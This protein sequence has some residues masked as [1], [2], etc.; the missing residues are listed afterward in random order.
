M[1]REYDLT[2]RPVPRIETQFRRIITEFPVPESVPILQRLQAHEPVAMRGQPP[3]VWDH[4]EGFQVYDAWGNQWI[5]WSSGVLIANAGHSRREIKDAIVRQ[6]S[7]DLLTNY[8]FPSEIRLR[9]VERLAA[10][11]PEPLKKVFLLTTG[12][13]AVECAI[14]LCRSHG[15]KVGGRTKH[16]IVSYDK[17]FHGRTLGSQQAG[18][19]PALKDWIVN[20]DP[21]FVQI[22]FP[23]GFRTADNSF[24]GFER[25]LRKRHVEP[26]DVAGV[27][28]ETYQGGSAAFAPAAYIQALRRWCLSHNALLVCDEVQ[29]AFGRTGTLWGFEH[30]GVVPDLALFGKGMSSSLP[31]SAVV[32]R[33]DVMDLHPAGSMTST[34]TG[35]PVCCAAALASIELVVSEKLAE[36]ARQVGGV[37][38]E[39]LGALQTRFPQIGR[40]DGKG[41]VAGIACV[42]PGTK[43]PDGD[44][45]W[46]VVERCVERGVLMFSPVGFGGGTVKI[47]PPLVITEAAILESV[48]VLEE[49]FAEATSKKTAVA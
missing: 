11:L 27:I 22:P 1:A 30:Y 38:Q 18:G 21:G 24:E 8:C 29:A 37:L 44:L 43:K 48:A 32:G 12:S 15:A 6:V 4:A 14:K 35:N 49:V 36:N 34:H 28:L 25:A 33:P 16:V 19:I 47:S 13:E 45:A 26:R 10:L 31:I 42:A 5:D 17:S 2:P 39:R 20:L 23:D 9:L 40:V 46:E 7:A 41:L 3:V